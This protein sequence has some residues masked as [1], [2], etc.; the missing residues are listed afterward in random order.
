MGVSQAFD[1]MTFRSPNWGTE[2]SRRAP[3]PCTT[4]SSRRPRARRGCSC[5]TP[6]VTGT[7]RT[8]SSPRPS[9]QRLETLHQGVSTQP[10]WKSPQQKELYRPEGHTTSPPTPPTRLIPPRTAGTSAPAPTRRTTLRTCRTSSRARCSLAW[11]TSWGARAACLTT[12]TIEV[13]RRAGEL[14]GGGDTGTWSASSNR[15]SPYP[16]PNVSPSR[17]IAS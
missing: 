14:W 1:N 11:G 13:C 5:P 8:A 10:Q 17:I 16:S 15:A 7:T 9:T 12:R 2:P 3:R 4:A 6:Q